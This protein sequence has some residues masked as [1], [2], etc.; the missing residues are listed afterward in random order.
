VATDVENTLQGL[1]FHTVLAGN[2][3]AANYQHTIVI[4]NSAA[5]GEKD[6]TARRLQRM[7]DARLVHEALP[8]QGAEIVVI[9]GSD[10]PAAPS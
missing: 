6:Y 7:L 4:E 5:P 10:L 3:D 2:A 1:G 9:V 8:G